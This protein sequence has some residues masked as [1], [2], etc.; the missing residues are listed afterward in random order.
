M[1]LKRIRFYWNRFLDWCYFGNVTSHTKA[2][3]GGVESEIEYR[4]RNNKIVGYWAYGS[5]D[6]SLPYPRGLQ[7]PTK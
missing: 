2:I 3:D 4:G 6:P 7:R 5:Y 1:I